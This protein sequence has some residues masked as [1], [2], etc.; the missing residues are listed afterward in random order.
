[1]SLSNQAFGFDDLMK[2]LLREHEPV[3]IFQYDGYWLD[4]GLRQTMNR[5]AKILT[6]SNQAGTSLRQK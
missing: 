3:N 4:I 2:T 1:M 6:A 5:L